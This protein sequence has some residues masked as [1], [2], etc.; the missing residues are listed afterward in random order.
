MENTTRESDRG[1]GDRRQTQRYGI[2]LHE[3]HNTRIYKPFSACMAVANKR[4]AV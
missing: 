3:K 1:T 2:G 4:E